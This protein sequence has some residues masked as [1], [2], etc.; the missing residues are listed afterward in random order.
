MWFG[1]RREG[2][3]VVDTSRLTR[4]QEIEACRAALQFV[5]PNVHRFQCDVPWDNKVLWPGEVVE[6]ATALA[7][8][9]Q[10]FTPKQTYQLTGWITGF[11]EDTWNAFVTFA[12]FSFGADAWTADMEWLIDVDD[13]GTSL[14]IRLS[15][16]RLADLQ[17]AVS[18]ADLVASAD[19]SRLRQEEWRLRQ[20]RK[21]RS[22]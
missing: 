20:N 18:G 21:H 15:P 4:D 7:P 14:A 13:E 19:W 10:N 2:Q 16:D 11:A 17:H 6:A 22:D 1:N 3:Y 9:P 8:L 12:P 5:R